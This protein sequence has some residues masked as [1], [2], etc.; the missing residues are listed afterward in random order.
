MPFLLP[1]GSVH[2]IIVQATPFLS[3]LAHFMIC[4]VRFSRRDEFVL[5]KRWESKARRYVTVMAFFGH[6]VKGV[7]YG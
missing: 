2:Y 6:A 4:N 5:G 7:G 1:I 3:Y